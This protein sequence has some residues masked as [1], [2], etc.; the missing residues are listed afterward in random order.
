MYDPALQAKVK[1]CLTDVQVGEIR[2]AFSMVD[3]DGNGSID[4]SELRTRMYLVAFRYACLASLSLI[5]LECS[6]ASDSWRGP[7]RSGYSAD[8]WLFSFLLVASFF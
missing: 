6:D 5:V 1:K 8:V 2:K 4:S 7:L 3:Q